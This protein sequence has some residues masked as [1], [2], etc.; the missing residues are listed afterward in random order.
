LTAHEERAHD[1]RAEIGQPN[2]RSE[3]ALILFIPRRPLIASMLSSSQAIA[4]SPSHG[5]TFV[6]Y[7]GGAPTAPLRQAALAAALVVERQ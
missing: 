2:K 6:P 4:L 3:P 1:F 7:N 5:E